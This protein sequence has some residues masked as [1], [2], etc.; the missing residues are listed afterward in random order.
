MSIF[1]SLG[2]NINQ[3]Y[4]PPN[5]LIEIFPFPI[6]EVDF[7]K[8][9][10]QNMFKRVLSDASDRISNLDDD[11]RNLFYDNFIKSE[12]VKG[13]LTHL[14]E[15][16]YEK[17][18]LYLSYDSA[19]NVIE[20]PKAEVQ[21]KIRLDYSQDGKSESGVY[22]SF[23]KYYKTDLLKIYSS[24]EY[25]TIAALYKQVNISKST[26][27]KISDLRKTVAEQDSEIAVEQAKKIAQ[28][29]KNGNDVLM[30]VGDTIESLIPNLEPVKASIDFIKSKQAFYLGMPRQYIDGVQNSGL[31]DT[32]EGESRAIDRGL[33][34]YFKSILKPILDSLFDMKSEFKS[35]SSIQVGSLLEMLKT[36]DITSDEYMD[37]E[38]KQNLIKKTLEG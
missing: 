33:K 31:G 5:E 36:F 29:L 2:F 32:G 1:K 9:D 27:V 10:V 19:L 18:D 6:Q 16:M 28:A 15:A 30:D 17:K 12:S 25:F 23:A 34:S 38:A 21:T 8:I 22:V 20:I 13:L 35:E 37:R 4:T 14:S 24:L 11:K 7:V 3:Q 26:Q